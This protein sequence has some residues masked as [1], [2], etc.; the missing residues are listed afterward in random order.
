MK[1]KVDNVPPDRHT[2][3]IHATAPGRLLGPRLG[4][5]LELGFLP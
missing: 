5:E 1:P 2:E 4:S 3:A